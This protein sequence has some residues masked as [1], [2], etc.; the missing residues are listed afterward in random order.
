[1]LGRLVCPGHSVYALTTCSSDFV[2][3]SALIFFK[4]KTTF[5]KIDDN[6]AQREGMRHV[7]IGTESIFSLT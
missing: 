6:T 5:E 3:S 1:M 4:A 2:N 7:N